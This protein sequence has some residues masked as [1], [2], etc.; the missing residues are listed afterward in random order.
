M[1]FLVTSAYICI[2]TW[3]LISSAIYIVAGSDEERAHRKTYWLSI[4]FYA[5]VCFACLNI[6]DLVV[7]TIYLLWFVPAFF[8]IWYG[9]ITVKEVNI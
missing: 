1:P 7:V 5:I 9:Y 2:G 4:L 6:K 3:Q 8:A